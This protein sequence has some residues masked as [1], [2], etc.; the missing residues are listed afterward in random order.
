MTLHHCEQRS[1]EW[2]ALRLGRVTASKAHLLSARNKNGGEPAPRRDYRTQFALERVTHVSQERDFQARDTD[3]G[4]R[5]EPEAIRAYE[6]HTG[7]IAMPI[8]FVSHDDLM[9]GCSPDGFVDDGGI[10]VKCPRPA[11][12]FANLRCRGAL[13]PDYLPQLQ[14]SCWITGASWWDLVSYCPQM[15]EG[16]RLYIAR[17]HRVEQDMNA[18]ELAVRFFLD[19]IEAEMREVEGL[20]AVTA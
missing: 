6:A 15:P 19:E 12:H 9:S 18:H 13:P 4:R 1:P 11:N 7:R 5:Y 20:M 17:Y 8:G 16:A 10:D 2:I 14:H 3:R